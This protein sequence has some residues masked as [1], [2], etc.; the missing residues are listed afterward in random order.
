[1]IVITQSL[2]LTPALALAS[3]SDH[4]AQ[5]SLPVQLW[6]DPGQSNILQSPLT[7]QPPS[8]EE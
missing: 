1:M 4:T 3:A 6:P 5:Q 2:R 7:L 8:H